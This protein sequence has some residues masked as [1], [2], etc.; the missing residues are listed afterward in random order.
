MT[1]FEIHYDFAALRDF[2]EEER[3]RRNL[4]G[5]EFAV[6]LG[7]AN[8]TLSR[9]ISYKEN[10]PPDPTIE[11]LARIAYATNTELCTLIDL[12]LG[13]I[14]EPNARRKVLLDQL[15]KLPASRQ[16][17]AILLLRALLI[18]FLQQSQGGEV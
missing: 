1:D 18:D 7:I 5:R 4:S 12:F 16:E 2:L 14:S 13:R 10:D 11:L 9:L 6:L 3:N 8:S 17:S 15:S